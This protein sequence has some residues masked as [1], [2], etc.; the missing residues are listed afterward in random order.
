[1]FKKCPKYFVTFAILSSYMLQPQIYFIQAYKMHLKDVLQNT[2]F[3]YE[4]DID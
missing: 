1:M 2:S 4:W 3:F